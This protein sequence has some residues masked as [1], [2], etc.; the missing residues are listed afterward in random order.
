MSIGASQSMPPGFAT[1][2]PHPGGMADNSPTFQ[3]WEFDFQW[4]QVPKGRLNR[5]PWSA[6]PSGLNACRTAVPN[7]ETLGYYRKSLR[8]KDL[9]AF[10]SPS[11]EKLCNAPFTRP[12][13]QGAGV[14]I[15]PHRERTPPAQTRTT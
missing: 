9:P 6:V 8:D 13:A 1:Q 12:T 15:V 10:R 4:I 7:V 2:H 3:R 14:S 11:P 5:C